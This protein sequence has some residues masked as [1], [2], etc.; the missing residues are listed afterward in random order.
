MIAILV[1]GACKRT[2]LEEATGGDGNSREREGLQQDAGVR[3]SGMDPKKGF[4]VRV[5]ADGGLFVGEQAVEG[6]ELGEWIRAFLRVEPE[7]HLRLHG[8]KGAVFQHSRK[9]IRLASA[10]GLDR[11]AFVTHPEGGDVDCAECRKVPA[12]VV[13][14]FED[15]VKGT[16]ARREQD[17]RMSLP[18]EIEP[19]GDLPLLVQLEAGGVVR[20]QGLDQTLAE[21]GESL[22]AILAQKLVPEIQLQVASD[23]PQAEVVEFLNLLSARGIQRV[24]FVELK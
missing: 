19:A 2:P 15:L 16:I 22:D 18:R 7:G 24:T 9:V 20:A 3:P 6:E 8:E 11:V 1:L 5:E 14:A 13:G 12:A 17:L 10:A 23:L 4:P 21:F